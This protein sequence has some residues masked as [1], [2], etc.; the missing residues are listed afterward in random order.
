MF[1]NSEFKKSITF[2]NGQAFYGGT[3]LFV[4]ICNSSCTNLI[5]RCNELLIFDV[6]WNFISARSLPYC[7]GGL[8]AIKIGNDL[9]YY[10]SVAGVVKLDEN[11]N[12]LNHYIQSNYY[13]FGDMYFNTSNNRLYCTI[14]EKF[15]G[16]LVFD[17]DL[18]FIRQLR[19][20]Y[21]NLMSIA[22]FKNKLYAASTTG[23]IWILENENI[24]SSF[25]T[26]SFRPINKIAFDVF[27]QLSFTNFD[28]DMH[29]Y[30]YNGNYLNISTKCP[31]RRAFYG[32]M[33]SNGNLIFQGYNGILFMEFKTI[34]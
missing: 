8:M 12:E 13:D 25:Q 20:G 22:E 5:P 4:T 31:A 30:D 34:Q 1:A 17:Q 23:I 26:L 32:G 28:E 19:V 24:L 6:N 16:L 3:R 11:F 15:N 2:V 14:P 29:V 18:V 33:D 27:G 9:V 21:D 7:L 10:G